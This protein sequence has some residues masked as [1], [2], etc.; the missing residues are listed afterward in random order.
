MTLESAGIS[1]SECV[2]YTGRDL[3]LGIDV[4]NEGQLA[5]QGG[6]ILVDVESSRIRSVTQCF[7]VVDGDFMVS[8]IIRTRVV[9]LKTH[10]HHGIW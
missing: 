9:A 2:A 4:R 10:R 8:W 1:T 3:P 6:F 5:S 7:K